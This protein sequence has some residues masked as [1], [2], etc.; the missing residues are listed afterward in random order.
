MMT[1]D[2]NT[3]ISKVV[4]SSMYK[5]GDEFNVRD[6]MRMMRISKST[7]THLCRALVERG[8][9]Q[10]VAMG[11]RHKTSRFVATSSTAGL[12]S[13]AWRR[14]HSIPNFSPRWR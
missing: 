12:I 2:R 4:T 3:Q 6:M 14:D 7:A 5:S 10:R 11:P 13:M 1:P 8:L 9:V